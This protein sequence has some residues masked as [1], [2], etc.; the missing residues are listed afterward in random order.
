MRTKAIKAFVPAWQIGP[1]RFAGRLFV[2]MAIEPLGGQGRSAS[3]ELAARAMLRANS[4][5]LIIGTSFEQRQSMDACPMNAGISNQGTSVAD[6]EAEF[7]HALQ[8]HHQHRPDLFPA[9]IPLVVLMNTSRAVSGQEAIDRVSL[10]VDALKGTAYETTLIKLEVYDPSTK[11]PNDHE[12]LL[13]AESLRKT[14]PDLFL[15]P[16]ITKNEDAAKHLIE[17]GCAGLR[18]F[19]TRIGDNRGLGD[20]NHFQRIVDAARTQRE[21][22]PIIA[23]GGIAYP[24]HILAARRAGATAVL[25]NSAILNYP[26][27]D[28]IEFITR[29]RRAAE[30]QV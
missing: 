30:R 7:K 19:G 10:F 4:N 28:R 29:L 6:I 25:V 23:E 18:I 5:V 26:G 15:V 16:F 2:P 1:Y 17:M 11:A 21:N 20:I 27:K 3:A 24:S 9:K 22:I 8:I 12:V 13:A 14:R